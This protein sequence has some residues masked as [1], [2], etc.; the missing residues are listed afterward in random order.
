MQR[1]QLKTCPQ[2]NDE[3]KVGFVT[4]R[5]RRSQTNPAQTGTET[6]RIQKE[7]DR[8]SIV[9]FLRPKRHEWEEEEE[10]KTR[11]SLDNEKDPE[12]DL[13]G[14]SQER[15][16]HLRVVEDGQPNS[17]HITRHKRTCSQQTLIHHHR[18]YTPVQPLGEDEGR[19][20]GLVSAV[21]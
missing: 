13:A 3:D 15:H 8:L 20:R 16:D 7:A 17:T 19:V 1:F 4:A 12:V 14:T 2:G 5:C 11:E 6:V 18:V 9:R 21:R 10:T